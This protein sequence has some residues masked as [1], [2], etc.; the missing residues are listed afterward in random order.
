M[1]SEVADG[2]P[3]NFP[4]AEGSVLAY[5]CAAARDLH[6][7]PC[8]RRAAKTRVPKNWKRAERQEMNVMGGEG[9]V[10]VDGLSAKSSSLKNLSPQDHRR[11]SSD[12]QQD[13]LSMEPADYVEDH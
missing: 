9:D 2:L 10:N 8:F 6:P 12:G 3:G 4:V 7:L 1:A 13:S 5:S 11:T